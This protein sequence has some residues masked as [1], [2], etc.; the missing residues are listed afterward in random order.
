MIL[1][2]IIYIDRTNAIEVTW[3]DDEGINVKC[4]CYAGDQMDELEADLG[5]DA[6]TY[7]DLI[8]ST[9]ARVPPYIPPPP[10]IPFSVTPFQAKAALLGAGLLPAVEAAIAAASPIAQLAWL[11][12]TAF[13]R[14]S[15]TIAAL[16]AQ[17]GLTPAQ[18]DALFTVAATIEA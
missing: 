4:R 9:R 8:A 5:A 16:S 3:V 12:A 13:T 6:A 2:Q 10:E 7:A 15:P 1:K 11:D 18:V 14:D 17:L